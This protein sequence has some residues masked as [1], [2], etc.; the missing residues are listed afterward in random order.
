[1]YNTNDDDA[2]RHKGAEWR[3][4]AA[5]ARTLATDS[6]CKKLTE[7][8]PVELVSAA[9]ILYGVSIFGMVILRVCFGT[10]TGTGTC[11]VT[12]TGTGITLLVL[13]A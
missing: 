11:T 3:S 12:G 8:S 2:Y 6:Y 9:F 10:G 7:A 4:D 1:M 13:V 5:A